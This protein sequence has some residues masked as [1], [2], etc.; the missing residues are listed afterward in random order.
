MFKKIA[1]CA[2]MVTAVQ[3]NAAEPVP[4]K[5]SFI[6][7]LKETAT[8]V[9][10]NSVQYGLGCHV[11]MT[12][13]GEAFTDQKTGITAST[14]N[15]T[16]R[17]ALVVQ[18]ARAAYY[19]AKKNTKKAKDVLKSKVTIAATVGTVFGGILSLDKVSGYLTTPAKPAAPAAE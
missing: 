2:L 19:A 18:L 5:K 3:L 17:V 6:D 4:V 9:K 14:I 10:D 11:D 8:S 1:L 13:D 12:K 15:S 16:S 7:S